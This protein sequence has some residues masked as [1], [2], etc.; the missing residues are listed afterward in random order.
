M[1][2]KTVPASDRTKICL[3]ELN[4]N[5]KKNACRLIEKRLKAKLFL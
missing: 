1:K 5:E 2:K 3:Y 4:T